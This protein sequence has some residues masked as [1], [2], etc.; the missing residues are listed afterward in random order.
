MRSMG[1]LTSLILIA[2]ALGACAPVEPPD[3]PELRMDKARAMARL[4]IGGGGLER[5]LDLGASLATEA[6]ADALVLELGRE[7]TAGER[8]RVEAIMRT[9]LAEFLTAEVLEDAAAEVYAAHFTAAELDRALAFF[10]SPTGA[11]I[12][13]LQRQIE[14]E[15]G[16]AL[17]AVVEAHLDA[18]ITSV[19]EGLAR[20]LPGLGAEESP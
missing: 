16:I 13:G 9:S 10:A 18:F 4:E 14:D 5:T 2:V 6:T 3:T 1:S 11:K 19:D 8:A 20:E 17:E 12:V 15:L 7:P